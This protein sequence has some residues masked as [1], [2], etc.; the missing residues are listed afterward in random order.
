MR[1]QATIMFDNMILGLKK[2]NVYKSVYSCSL[3][4]VHLIKRL[5]GLR[6]TLINVH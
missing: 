4:N 1:L 6:A 5:S 2:K 3:I